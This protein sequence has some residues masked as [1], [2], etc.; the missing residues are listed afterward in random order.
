MKQNN[1]VIITSC[2][3]TKYRDNVFTLEERFQ[4]TLH[5][6]N[7]VKKYM[8]NTKILFIEASNCD[9]NYKSIINSMCD[10]YYDI[11]KETETLYYCIYGH[12]SL[13]DTYITLKAIEYIEN[14]GL[15]FNIYYKLSGRYYPEY[16][17]NYN[18]I[19]QNI[20]TF[21][22]SIYKPGKHIM[23]FFY[24]IPFNFLS[25]YK[26]NAYITVEFMKQ[27]TDIPVEEYLPHLF[28]IKKLI[29]WD[30]KIGIN[31]IIAPCKDKITQIW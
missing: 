18:L 26:E 13:G 31:G 3:D 12:K 9:D 11:S 5:S 1:L 27:R 25:Q 17:F 2:L 24:A 28:K 22:D 29:P 16:Y 8:I 6:I 15:I 10:Y 21:K 20:P 19:N 4:Q 23:T 14:N 30:T 7:C